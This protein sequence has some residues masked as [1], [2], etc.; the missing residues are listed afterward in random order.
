MAE[1]GA[2]QLLSPY[3][4]AVQAYKNGESIPDAIGKTLFGF[5]DKTPEQEQKVIAA[6]K[7]ADS[8]ARGR[9]RKPH[10]PIE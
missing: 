2:Q 7:R 1:F 8:E 3:N 5:R 10:G 4:D 9:V 6:K